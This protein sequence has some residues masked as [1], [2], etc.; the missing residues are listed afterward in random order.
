MRN[1]K[2]AWSAAWY[3]R[4]WRLYNC[5]KSLFT[6][7]T[8]GLNFWPLHD[9]SETKIVV[10]AIKLPSFSFLLG[11]ADTAYLYNLLLIQKWEIHFFPVF[12]WFLNIFFSKFPFPLRFVTIF[13]SIWDYFLLCRIWW[14]MNWVFPSP[15]FWCLASRHFLQR[16]RLL[17]HRSSSSAME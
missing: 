7:W 15:P 6:R 5:Q 17:S 10:A 1:M 13:L 11:Q 14:I 2:N 16:S 8:P 12:F 9:T 4:H 3:A